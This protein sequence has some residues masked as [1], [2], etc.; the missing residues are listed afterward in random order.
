MF[1]DALKAAGFPD[2]I[3]AQLYFSLYHGHLAETT[4]QAGNQLLKQADRK[5]KLMTLLQYPL[6]LL[7]FVMMMLLAMRF[8]L[9]PHMSDMTS[10]QTTELDLG[11]RFILDAVYHAPLILLT[12]S[13]LS[14]CGTAGSHAESSPSCLR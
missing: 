3:C 12:G 11:T 9:L 7:F 6:V 1:S 8:I 13:V 4:L 5:R 10:M 14:C 2:V